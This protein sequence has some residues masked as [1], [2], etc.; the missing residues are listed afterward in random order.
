MNHHFMESNIL[1][2]GLTKLHFL[3]E[4]QCQCHF[5][6]QVGMRLYSTVGY[7]ITI[8]EVDWDVTTPGLLLKACEHPP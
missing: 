3:G 8:E 7:W 1:Y 5:Q 4:Y 2:L 6:N